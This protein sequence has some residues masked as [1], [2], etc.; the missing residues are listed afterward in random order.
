MVGCPFCPKKCLSTIGLRS[1]IFWKHYKKYYILLSLAFLVAGFLLNSGY[2]WFNNKYQKAK[3]EPDVNIEITKLKDYQVEFYLE[4]NTLDGG[5]IENFKFQFEIPGKI[6][7]ISP[8]FSE[9]RAADCEYSKKEKKLHSIVHITCESIIPSGWYFLNI[10]YKPVQRMYH[11]SEN[12]ITLAITDHDLQIDSL[13]SKGFEKIFFHSPDFNLKDYQ[14]YLFY[15]LF[16]GNYE[17]KVGCINLSDVPFIQKNNEEL[18]NYEEGKF[19]LYLLRE[20]IDKSANRGPLEEC[21]QDMEC[22][23]NIETERGCE[24]GE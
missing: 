8:S 9:E 21:Y 6:I 13:K 7:N 1:H 18:I 20:T 11:Y 12:G 19:D 4:S 24:L 17:K 3:R 5:K 2:D 10:N 15:W 16:N 23:K 14:D 22:L